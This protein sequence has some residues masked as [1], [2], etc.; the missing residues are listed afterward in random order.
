MGFFFYVFYIE[1]KFILTKR[2]ERFLKRVSLLKEFEK[3][4]LAEVQENYKNKRRKE[5]KAKEALFK[6]KQLEIDAK[7]QQE[8]FARIS[9]EVEKEYAE[10][11][12]TDK[13]LLEEVIKSKV[14][15][16]EMVYSLR[17]QELK[18]Y[19]HRGFLTIEE[20]LKK[21]EV[22]LKKEDEK[23]RKEIDE[24]KWNWKLA[25]SDSKK[26]YDEYRKKKQKEREA[27]WKNKQV[28]YAEKFKSEIFFRIRSEAEKEFAEKGITD[29]KLLEDYIKL[30]IISEEK[31][32]DSKEKIK[33]DS[34][35]RISNE[36]EKEFA[37]KGVIDINILE[38]TVKL[39]IISEEKEF[40]LKEKV[41]QDTYLRIKNEVEKEYAEKGITNKKLLEDIIKLRIISE[42]KDFVLNEKVK[43]DT[44][45]RI[46]NEVEK[47]FD[48]EEKIG[49]DTYLKISEAEKE[50][51]L[52]EKALVLKQNVWKNDYLRIK[53]EVEK[54]F[55]LKGITDEKLLE[56][57]IK[58]EIRLE[59]N[60]CVEKFKLEIVKNRI[61]E[62]EKEFALKEKESALK[63]IM[64][65]NNYFRI[66]NEV[67]KEYAEKGIT[68][69]N[70]LEEAIKYRIS[71]A[72]KEF[73]LKEKIGKDAY[74]RI[75]YEVEK[76]FESKR[77]TDE[78][79]LEEAVKYR[80]AKEY[81][82]IKLKEE[83]ENYSGKMFDKKEGFGSIQF[84]DIIELRKKNLEE[85]KKEQEKTKEWWRK[86]RE[87]EEKI[88]KEQKVKWAW[89]D[90]K[91]EVK[92]D[93]E[94]LKE[95]KEKEELLKNNPVEKSLR[96]QEKEEELLKKKYEEKSRKEQEKT[97][98]WWRKKREEEEKII[99]E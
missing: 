2:D 9:N 20:L 8:R 29:K 39:R 38:E 67:E 94:S 26:D 7:V 15:E 93:E 63:L 18:D 21:K 13:N 28:K 69:K 62:A 40:A 96:E 48:S 88:I 25:L 82:K 75:V 51:T 46:K 90:R 19:F 64:W 85:W 33:Q 95:Q 14:A 74:F 5:L 68:D 16:E 56:D 17:E 6:K 36:V 49:R 47:E 30:R 87:E 70:L 4:K 43:R 98:E 77:I 10:K 50:L 86:K 66:S 22:E 27:W 80:V 73:A 79:L 34:Y 54:K 81:I 24:K 78:K 71:E 45:L 97:K 72:E 65:K 99:K 32:F 91:K 92:N 44:Y 23:N 59:E 52:K 12:I 89:L 55:A 61:S 53:N 42:E 3:A 1:Y 11:G 58:L 41:K 84:D 37:L 35:L 31:D 57:Y 76:E 83:S 60:V